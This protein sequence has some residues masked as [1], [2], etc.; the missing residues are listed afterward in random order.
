MA[1]LFTACYQKFCC[2]S[3]PSVFWL[4]H[5][6]QVIITKFSFIMRKSYGKFI[7]VHSGTFTFFGWK[8]LQ[9]LLMVS[10][11]DSSVLLSLDSPWFH[12]SFL[13][14]G[15]VNLLWW[16]YDY[17]SYS[18][19]FKG[20]QPSRF[21]I[22]SGQDPY[23]NKLLPKAHYLKY[24]VRF[25]SFII[26]LCLGVRIQMFKSVDRRNA[27]QTNNNF[28]GNNSFTD[29]TISCVAIV[30]FVAAVIP[31]ILI[32]EIPPGDFNTFPNYA[33]V[34][35]LQIFVPLTMSL[36]IITAYFIRNPNIISCLKAKIYQFWHWS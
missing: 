26:H 9:L 21:Y 28:L 22:C 1:L 16:K 35:F 5:C 34:Y 24:I 3:R 30:M 13:Y 12:N 20:H 10:G 31:A 29:L 23:K 15:Q 17:I 6:L 27:V 33:Y 2:D 18:N 32:E 36:S 25:G 19:L 7:F 11:G 14:F 8:I 4:S